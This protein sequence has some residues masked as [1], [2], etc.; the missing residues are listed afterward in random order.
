EEDGLSKDYFIALDIADLAEVGKTIGIKFELPATYYFFVSG[1]DT[2]SNT[3]L[4]FTTISA[5]IQEYADVVTVSAYRDAKGEGV[6]PNEVV[7]GQHNI[8]VEQI[9]LTTK[10]PEVG[11]PEAEA[12]W[13][14]VRVSLNGT[15]PDEYITGIRVYRDIDGDERFSI[16]KDLLIGDA[17]TFTSGAANILFKN[18]QV[19]DADIYSA[20]TIGKTYM[21][22][23]EN[24]Y[25]GYQIE[26]TGGKGAGQK[27]TIVAN[28][29]DTFYVSPAW[30]IVPD[31]TSDFRIYTIQTI[32]TVAKTYFIVYD[33][34]INA[35]PLATIGSKF[36]SPSYFFISQPNVCRL[37][38][39]TPIES[40]TATIR[41]MKVYFTAIDTASPSAIQTEANVP[42]ISFNISVHPDTIESVAG[43]PELQGI[44]LALTYS[45][46]PGKQPSD[47]DKDVYRIKVYIDA[48][49]NRSF[50]RVWNP[51]T[52]NYEVIG[53][54]LVSSGNDT[55]SGNVAEVYFTEP[56]KL[57][58]EVK[59]F[60][61]CVDIA[62]DAGVDDEIG[63]RIGHGTNDW[64]FINPPE[65]VIEE[66]GFPIESSLV[67]IKS[68]YQ[69]KKPE[70]EIPNIWVASQEEVYA[71]WKTEARGGVSGSKYAVGIEP[72]SISNLTWRLVT[73]YELEGTTV[74]KFE[75]TAKVEVTL[76]ENNV[77]YFSA[78]AISAV[79]SEESEV[80][81][82]RFFVDVTAPSKPGKPTLSL[83]EGEVGDTYWVKWSPSRDR[84]IDNKGKDHLCTMGVTQELINT[85][86][87]NNWSYEADNEG[88]ITLKTQ[89]GTTIGTFTGY[90]VDENGDVKY[91]LI[92]GVRYYE[93]QERADTSPRWHTISSKISG[94]A[95]TFEVSPKITEYEDGTKRPL[96]AHFYYYRIRSIDRAGNKSEWSDISQM[97]LAEV[98]SEIVS[99][100]S[101]YPNPVDATKKDEVTITYLLK[102]DSDVTITIYD[103]FGNLVKEFHFGRGEDRSFGYIT[104]PD[105]TTFERR[106][107]GRKGVNDIVW[108]LRTDFGL[109]VAKGGY[110]L[111]MVVKS[112]EGTSQ[113]IK[114][115]GVIR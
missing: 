53:D 67:L 99:E 104:L 85:W 113:V 22:W 26:I 54:S 74:Y 84:F 38:K 43:G 29:N 15:C 37:E 30:D 34:S 71:R 36:A 1:V 44:K 20:Y 9:S 101:I 12:Q 19:V 6:I 25:V 62:Q 76:Q 78:K 47:F 35:P 103:L 90:Y 79:T 21:N 28:T 55:F 58:E 97:A 88:I 51:S 2:V 69:P 27:R 48:N 16:D 65:R 111:R 100:V 112:P 72:G 17:D 89:D 73:D 109:K 31:R 33:L 13:T 14:G 57:T 110:I 68:M 63:I 64:I 94:E 10:T 45:G 40:K 93:L 75:A 91:V 83:K 102:Y 52:L 7:Q 87:A 32:G 11:D 8:L 98:P 106:G 108:D 59:T 42:M 46:A 115:I 50:D 96:N 49:G 80:G 86:E 24:E 4:P 39:D 66:G 5:E 56:V 107:G 3:N 60:F 105:G 23:E 61:I 81:A 82:A 77:Y 95:Q 41:P 92:S 114:K 18:V 70:V